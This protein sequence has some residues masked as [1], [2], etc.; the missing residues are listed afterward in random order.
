MNDNIQLA[1]RFVRL[2]A[3]GIDAVLVIAF[4]LLL[5]LVTGA[6]E[7]AEDYAHYPGMRILGLGLASYLILNGWLLWS[8]GQTL[9]KLIFGIAMV[10]SGTRQ[11]VPLW[12]SLLL[13][14][15]VFLIL[16]IIDELPVFTKQRKCIHDW[17]AGTQVI[18]R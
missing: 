15:P 8:R 7:T 1:S 14:G 18:K 9:G 5:L 12:K 4:A 10:K 2:V 3:T 13:R 17:V 16:P 11:I 6:L